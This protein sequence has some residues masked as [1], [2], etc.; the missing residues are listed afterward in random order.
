MQRLAQRI[1]FIA[2][3]LCG[4]LCSAFAV[5]QAERVRLE[6]VLAVDSSS[7]VTYDEFD[8]Q[9]EGI[10]SAFEDP[11]VLAAIEDSGPEGIAV[12]LLQ[13]SSLSVQAFAVE[14]TH[15]RGL[16]DSLAFAERVRR[17][18]RQVDGGATAMSTALTEAI[19][20]L[21]SNGFLGERQVI[22]VSG[23]G[24]ANE[25]ESPAVVRA[26]ANRIGIT[27]NGLAILNEEPRLDRY[28][29]A[30]VVGGPGSFLLTADDFDDFAESM[31]N[32]L[33][34]EIVGPPIAVLPNDRLYSQRMQA[35]ENGRRSNPL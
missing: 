35:P 32:K 30:G 12:T 29:L 34:F 2:S 18:G 1:F 17:A 11:R 25:G 8:L 22:D 21:E 27:I 28:Y 3:L 20:A 10:A 4:W 31:R 26:F 13:W 33:Y 6:L 5:A 7:S 9:M 19:V 14:W 24:R 23:D 15:I 16:A